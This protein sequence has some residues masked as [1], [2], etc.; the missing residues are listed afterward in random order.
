MGFYLSNS[1]Y[2][3]DLVT[4]LD[5]HP[6]QVKFGIHISITENGTLIPSVE[7]S[8]HLDGHIHADSNQKSLVVENLNEGTEYNFKVTP[9]LLNFPNAKFLEKT[10]DFKETTLASCFCDNLISDN[11]ILCRTGMNASDFDWFSSK[12]VSL[13]ESN[14][15]GIQH[16]DNSSVFVDSCESDN[17]INSLKYLPIAYSQKYSP[18]INFYRTL[19][20]CN[21][22][23]TD[24]LSGCACNGP[25]CNGVQVYYDECR[26]SDHSQSVQFTDNQLDIYRNKASSGHD[27]VSYCMTLNWYH[28]G[29]LFCTWYACTH[30]VC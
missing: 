10:L 15:T 25:D 8:T 16:C 11:N 14:V 2:V 17:T 26:G 18:F 30:R 13:M 28:V 27:I 21:R 20:K 23:D 22:T 7:F 3:F 4:R 12:C 1:F 29:G 5:D 9:F 19:G 24:I 6:V